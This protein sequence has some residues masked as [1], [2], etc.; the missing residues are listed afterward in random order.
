MKTRSFL[1]LAAALVVACSGTGAA[2]PGATSSP[3]GTSVA[4]GTPAASETSAASPAPSA[5]AEGA[6]IDLAFIDMMV[7]HHQSAVEMAKLATERAQHPEL[8]TMADEIIAAQE[9]EIA[10]LKGWRQDWFGSDA[11]PPMD[12]MPMLP[13]ME[14]P[15]MDDHGMTGSTMDMTADIEML[16]SATDFDETFLE[17]MTAHHEM[18]IEAANLVLTQTERPEI[19]GLAED[20]IESQQAEI[21]QMGEW[22][23]E[24]YPEAS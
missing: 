10:Q 15:G 2:T 18:A 3:A 8:R 1:I 21:D 14:M 6:A 19:R 7:P 23:A 16:R 9:R 17:L 4:S 24:W 12:A 13:G 11:T 20:V 5:S 22:R